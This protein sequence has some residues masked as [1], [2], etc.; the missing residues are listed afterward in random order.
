MLLQHFLSPTHPSPV[1]C[2]SK[3]LSEINTVTLLAVPIRWIV[4]SKPLKY[5]Y[6]CTFIFRS[7]IVFLSSSSEFPCNFSSFWDVTWVSMLEAS[8]GDITAGVGIKKTAL[9]FCQTNSHNFNSM[10]IKWGQKRRH[11]P[12]CC[13]LSRVIYRF[14]CRPL[15][16]SVS[17]HSAPLTPMLNLTVFSSQ[18]SNFELF[19]LALTATFF[20]SQKHQIYVRPGL[21]PLT[22]LKWG[23]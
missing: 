18:D 2:S 12:P 3:T 21:E 4:N 20:T 6:L 5:T 22:L 10:H 1:S 15:K 14:C 9:C 17:P 11:L 13:P 23:R 16:V 7:F 8:S 19:E